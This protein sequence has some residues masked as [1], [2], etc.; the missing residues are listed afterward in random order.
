MSHSAA[1][2]AD[3]YR[4]T[5]QTVEGLKVVNGELTRAQQTELPLLRG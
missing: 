4:K 3:T 2:L 1:V 5:G